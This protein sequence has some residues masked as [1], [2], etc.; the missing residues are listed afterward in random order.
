M[1]MTSSLAFT[2]TKSAEGDST[3]RVVETSATSPSNAF[4]ITATTSKV[5]SCIRASA[6]AP[7]HECYFNVLTYTT[8]EATI[9]FEMIKTSTFPW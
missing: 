5:I 7:E 6:E 1:L 8:E 2:F 4:G 3:T 9:E